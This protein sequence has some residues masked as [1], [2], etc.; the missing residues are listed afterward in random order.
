LRAWLKWWS[1]LNTHGLIFNH[2]Y[3]REKMHRKV[4]GNRRNRHLTGRRNN[5]E[6]VSKN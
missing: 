5:R 3:Q 6:G 1:H 2:Q 4:G